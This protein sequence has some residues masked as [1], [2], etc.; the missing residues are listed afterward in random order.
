MDLGDFVNSILGSGRLD[1]I[2]RKSNPDANSTM[3]DPMSGMN[4]PQTQQP[5]QPPSSLGPSLNL[6]IPSIGNMNV[7][8]NNPYDPE[9]VIKAGASSIISPAGEQPGQL[10]GPNSPPPGS[11]SPGD[12]GQTPPVPPFA[13]M[14]TSQPPMS[15]MALPPTQT[16]PPISRMQ[17]PPGQ[18]GQQ[19]VEPQRGPPMSLAP[20]PQSQMAQTPLPPGPVTPQQ[21]Q[22]W[23]GKL[24]GIDPKQAPYIGQEIMSGMGAGLKSVGEN[25]NKPGLAAFAASAGSGIEGTANA[26][27]E[28][29]QKL[30][31]AIRNKAVD[32]NISL[33]QARAEVLRLNQAQGK[34]SNAW[35]MSEPGRFHLAD[36]EVQKYRAAQVALYRDE[37]KQASLEGDQDKLKKIRDAINK[38]VDER[39]KQIHKNLGLDQSKKD[40]VINKGFEGPED[41]IKHLPPGTRYWDPKSKQPMIRKQ[42]EHNTPVTGPQMQQANPNINDIVGQ[43]ATE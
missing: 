33:S 11:M 20:P 35:Q 19:P 21:R 5:A 17:V 31:Q 26:R 27:K 8:P 15:R 29:E 41:V 34:A 22:A 24:L 37:L 2:I 12:T 14:A 25:W 42:D 10:G 39:S 38:D 13:P 7:S 1:E 40:A 36:M 18:I 6:P 43:P 16:S 9:N 30:Q 28:Q 3:T 23:L 32:A 4:M